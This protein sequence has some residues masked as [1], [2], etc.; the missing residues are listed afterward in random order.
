MD[1]KGNVVMTIFLFSLIVYLILIDVIYFSSYIQNKNKL[2]QLENR[3]N[4]IKL[5]NDYLKVQIKNEKE[6]SF[7]EKVARE[8]LMLAKKGETVIYFNFN[9]N[10]QPID[11]KQSTANENFFKKFFYKLLHHFKN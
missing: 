6:D 2:A 11:S 1:R 9:R 10:K 5:Q 8:K 4:A 3:V 7:I